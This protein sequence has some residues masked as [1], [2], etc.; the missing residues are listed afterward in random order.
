MI[1]SG[2]MELHTENFENYLDESYC[3]EIHHNGAIYHCKYDRASA[4][5]IGRPNVVLS[6]NK[7]RDLLRAG[8]IRLYV[9]F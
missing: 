5:F 4:I 6:I 3:Y 8:D 1:S 9:A 2:A 7:V